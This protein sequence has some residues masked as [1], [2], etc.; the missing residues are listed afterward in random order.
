MITCRPTKTQLRTPT[1][2]WLCSAISISYVAALYVIVPNS[3][4]RLSRD[5]P[6]QIRWRSLA[7]VI[8]GAI[9]II[10]SRII[11]CEDGLLSIS[12]L[13]IATFVYE[14]RA[15]LIAL[16]HVMVLYSCPLVRSLIRI[17]RMTAPNDGPLA[18]LKALVKNYY[19][20]CTAPTIA[21]L[22]RTD[23]NEQL[24]WVLLRNYILAPL[25]EEI[26]FRG[27]IIP[28][29]KA[30]GMNDRLIIWVSPLFFGFAH[31]HHAFV[32]Y[33][34]GQP[35]LAILL[36]TIVQF[37]YTTLF[38]LYAS[39][40]F[41]KTKSL[42][43]VIVAHSFCNIM[44]LPDLSFFNQA[45]S[46][47]SSRILLGFSLVVGIVGFSLGLVYEVLPKAPQLVKPKGH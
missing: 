28:I 12:G 24:Q 23:G 10:F 47:Y 30:S 13:S 21:G 31:I 9:S 45:S 16:G 8:V 7:T 17:S 27:S 38:G 36:Q 44:G 11:S 26:V 25:T 22:L 40:I 29:L 37:A 43:A 1:A 32:K 6:R 33:C 4:Q 18:T 20:I 46:F 14:A 15:T 39:F 3:I 41:L 19:A 35:L 34:Q 2:L 5:D 42:W